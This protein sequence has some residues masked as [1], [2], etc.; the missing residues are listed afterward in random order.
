MDTAQA[1][2]VVQLDYD[3]PDIGSELDKVDALKGRFIVLPNVSNGGKYTA[4]KDAAHAGFKRMSY[5]GGYV[6]RGQ[7]VRTVNATNRR[8]MSGEDQ[9]WGSRYIYPLPTSDFLAVAPQRMQEE[10]PRRERVR[11]RKAP[12]CLLKLQPGQL[13]GPARSMTLLKPPGGGFYDSHPGSTGSEPRR[14]T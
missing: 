6:D 11:Q 5:V 3:Y 9:M 13:Q 2:K 8:R 14:Q 7:N 4:L 10:S 12:A 1:Q